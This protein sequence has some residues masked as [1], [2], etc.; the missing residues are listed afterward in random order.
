MK[1]ANN[2]AEADKVLAFLLPMLEELEDSS[3][4]EMTIG[5]YQNGREQGH[6]LSVVNYNDGV[7][8]LWAAFSEARRSDEIVVYFGDMDPLKSITDEM[9]EN[10]YFFEAEEHKQAAEFIMGLVGRVL[11][12]QSVVSQKAK[13]KPVKKPIS[14]EEAEKAV[15]GALDLVHNGSA[16]KGKSRKELL[17]IAE[18]TSKEV[19][20][21][22]LKM[23]KEKFT[24]SFKV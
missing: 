7:H 19:V 15:I 23:T 11:S 3:L 5:S 9:Y 16:S 13:E 20:N 12:G 10:A 18:E 4:V 22:A 17:G 14:V 8:M 1:V 6:S 24:V 2:R 21:M